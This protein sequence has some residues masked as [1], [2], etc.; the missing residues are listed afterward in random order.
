ME[1]ARHWRLRE[2]RLRFTGEKK[3]A[4]DGKE[5]VS[6]NGTNWT[7]YKNGH[8]QENIKDTKII[9]QAPQEKIPVDIAKKLEITV[10]AD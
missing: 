10:S 8:E 4:P 1:I 6:L 7:E 3:V 9:Y 5:F 2:H